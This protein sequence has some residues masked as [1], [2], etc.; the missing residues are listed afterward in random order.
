MGLL[1]NS[2]DFSFKR[3][4]EAAKRAEQ[5]EVSRRDE[6]EGDFV[7]TMGMG[8]KVALNPV[9]KADIQS[10]ITRLEAERKAKL[11]EKGKLWFYQLQAHTKVDAEL[12][13]LDMKIRMLK[14]RLS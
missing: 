10:Q 6:S 2:G 4:M 14:A 13:S 8:L 9:V 1:V 3:L 11:E 12:D 5:S 7:G